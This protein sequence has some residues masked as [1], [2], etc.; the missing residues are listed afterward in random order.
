MKGMMN[1]VRVYIFTNDHITSALPC[2]HATLWCGD[3]A[4]PSFPGRKPI[5]C[6][7]YNV[8]LNF[9]GI[10]FSKNTCTYT[11]Q[12]SQL[13][14]SCYCSISIGFSLTLIPQNCLGSISSLS[15]SR[16]CECSYQCFFKCLVELI[17]FAF[18]D[19]QYIEYC[20]FD[21]NF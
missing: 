17:V 20:Y 18:V 12:R 11:H 21:L 7:L 19:G 4:A 5:F 8:L 2:N 14:V 9:V 16:V 10:Y 13:R 15:R 3:A 6:D 1:F